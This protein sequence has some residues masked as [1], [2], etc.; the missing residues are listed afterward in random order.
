MLDMKKIIIILFLP[1]L[2]SSSCTAKKDTN[3]T[4][5][6][7][8]SSEE[9]ERSDQILKEGYIK[10]IVVDKSKNECGFVLKNSATGEFLLPN[11][12]EERF[13]QDGINVWLKYTLIRPIQGA[14]VIGNPIA[15]NEIK[16]IE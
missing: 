3:E 10:A 4:E 13:K 8:S 7:K 12:L 14:C 15:I 1:V 6:K 5:R 16:R 2:L 9:K 11:N